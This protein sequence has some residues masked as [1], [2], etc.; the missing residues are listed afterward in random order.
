LTKS[1]KGFNLYTDAPNREDSNAQSDL[2][3]GL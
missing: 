2:K 3:G 1:K